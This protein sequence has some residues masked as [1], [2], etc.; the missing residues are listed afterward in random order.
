VIQNG[1]HPFCH[2][3]HFFRCGFLVMAYKYEKN[4][5]FLLLIIMSS[6]LL[7]VQINLEIQFLPSTNRV[8]C[9]QSCAL[10]IWLC[11]ICILASGLT[12]DSF[13]LWRL[14]SHFLIHYKN[15]MLVLYWR[16]MCTCF[17]IFGQEPT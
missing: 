5:M 16:I 10:Y 1:Y 8:K 11:N 4:F 15:C 17:T 2:K 9:T 6:L 14:M 3:R 7:R 12:E 13:L